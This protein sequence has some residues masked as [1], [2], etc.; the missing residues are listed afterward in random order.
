MKNVSRDSSFKH[1]VKISRKLWPVLGVVFLILI[2]LSC[3]IISG[4]NY[5][6][7]R[8]G[9]A[10]PFPSHLPEHAESHSNSA[11]NASLFVSSSEEANSCSHFLMTNRFNNNMQRIKFALYRCWIPI[12]TVNY[13]NSQPFCGGSIYKVPVLRSSPDLVYTESHGH[14]RVWRHP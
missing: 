7:P 6:A 5:W 12:F 2:F 13:I 1:S 14:A 9:G 4:I 8:G 3:P 11:R 10:R